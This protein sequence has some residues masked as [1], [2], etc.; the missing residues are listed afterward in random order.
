MELDYLRFKIAAVGYNLVQ[1]QNCRS[2]QQQ[3]YW[4]LVVDCSGRMNSRK[5]RTKSQIREINFKPFGPRNP[6][7]RNIRWMPKNES[8]NLET[9]ALK[10]IKHGY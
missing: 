1:F 3:Q 10:I 2:R 7:Q 6:G 9:V 4:I 8:N 5:I